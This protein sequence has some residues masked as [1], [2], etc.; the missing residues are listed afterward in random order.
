VEGIEADETRCRSH[1]ETSTAVATA[2]LPALG[3]EHTCA[4]VARSRETGRTVRETV[5]EE[6]LLTGEELEQLL[7][8]EAVTRLGTPQ[9]IG[10]RMET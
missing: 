2:L 6:G 5:L 1:V 9:S 8:P 3:Y 7:S 10:Y 4:V